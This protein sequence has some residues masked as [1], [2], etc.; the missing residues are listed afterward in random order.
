M[1]KK[2]RKHI[3]IVKLEK[4]THMCSVVVSFVYDGILHVLRIAEKFIVSGSTKSLI[5]YQL[6]K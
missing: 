4:M 3:L 2:N 5:I 6:L 1:C